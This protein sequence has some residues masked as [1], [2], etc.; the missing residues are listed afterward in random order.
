M[1]NDLCLPAGQC[2][3]LP[4]YATLPVSIVLVHV[5]VWLL[6]DSDARR[7]KVEEQRNKH[8]FHLFKVLNIS[9]FHASTSKISNLIKYPYFFTLLFTHNSVKDHFSNKHLMSPYQILVIRDTKILWHSL[10]PQDAHSL[11]RDEE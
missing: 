11:E 7:A 10:Y 4:S 3:C 1:N 9:A 8:C 6:C 2:L 5:K